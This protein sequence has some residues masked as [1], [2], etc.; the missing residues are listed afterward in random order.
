MLMFIVLA[1]SLTSQESISPHVRTTDPR[2]LALVDAG[3]SGSA[4]F[5]GLIATLNESDVIVYIESNHTR[6]ALGGYL[7]HNIVSQGQY[8]YLRIAIDIA[9]SER[10]LVSLLAHELQHAVEVAQAPDARDSESLDRLF[11]RLAITFGCGG[12]SCFETQAA[13]DVERRVTKE[14]SDSASLD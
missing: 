11:S 4:T 3:I 2:I 7:A 14:L 9:G 13:K 1:L 5:R 10:R 6:Q 12:T 8:R